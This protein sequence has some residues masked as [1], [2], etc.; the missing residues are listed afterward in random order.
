MRHFHRRAGP[1][2]TTPCV[3]H[4]YGPFVSGYMFVRV[5]SVWEDLCRSRGLDNWLVLECQMAEEGIMV[6]SSCCHELEVGV[7][8]PQVK[9]GVQSF[10]CEWVLCLFWPPP[11][12]PFQSCRGPF[13]ERGW[14]PRNLAASGWPSCTSLLSLFL[15]LG[16]PLLYSSPALALSL[17]LPLPG[18]VCFV[19]C[20]IFH[21][22]YFILRPPFLSLEYGQKGHSPPSFKQMKHRGWKEERN[23]KG[24]EKRGRILFWTREG[25]GR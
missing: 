20:L 12:L 10:I 19:P 14:E 6:D 3:M 15:F 9:G 25:N 13:V 16:P 21:G 18:L 8:R 7:W 4:H 11:P 2:L 17:C 24:K 22:I 5:A 23:K 1:P